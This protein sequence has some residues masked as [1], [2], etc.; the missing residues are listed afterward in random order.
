EHDRVALVW[1]LA[2]LRQQPRGVPRRRSTL[3][4]PSHILGVAFAPDGQT[5]AMAYIDGH[6]R[7][8]DLASGSKRADF[9]H[10]ARLDSVAFSPDGRTLA[11]GCADGAVRLFDLATSEMW[12]ALG[13]TAKVWS[14]A[15][16][17]SGNQLASAGADK[18]VHVWQPDR[19]PARRILH[20]SADA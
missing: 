12:T 19:L 14:V 15:F 4:F 20:R 2:P 11:T 3:R 8:W 10:P 16:S 5:L 13:H 7:L 6:A 1:D 18:T 9:Q 17:P